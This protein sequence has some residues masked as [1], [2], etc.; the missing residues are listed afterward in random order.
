MYRVPD[1]DEVMAVAEDLGIH[2][3]PDEATLY[4]KHL[5][6]VLREVD[7]FV[8]ARLPEHEPPMA[9]A[10][11]APGHRPS[12][13][14][15]PLNAWT[16]KCRIEGAAGGVLAG[17]TVSFKDHIAVAGMP[18]SLGAFAL[19][20]FVPDFDA[21]VVT[22]VLQAG[23]TII[24]KNV[25]NGLSGGFGTGG[26]IGDYGRPLNPH[27]H[28]HVTGGSS[29]G[30]GAAVAAGQVDISFG[31]ALD[32]ALPHP[33]IEWVFFGARTRA[34]FP[35]G[36]HHRRPGFLHPRLHE[37]IELAQL[38]HEVLSVEDGLFRAQMDAKLPGH[39]HDFVDVRH[40]VHVS[41][42]S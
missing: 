21:T 8:Q 6:E 41:L 28:E 9:S 12:P 16:W 38:L 23:G 29:S 15:D 5:L 35:A 3:G 26:A 34:W 18:M 7:T 25:M 37:R 20:G 31:G 30:S 13:E 11:R 24:G 1:V 40:R 33:R 19:E 22:R 2:L 42:L 17:K 4:R 10:A 27:R 14:E 36:R 32:P 39:R